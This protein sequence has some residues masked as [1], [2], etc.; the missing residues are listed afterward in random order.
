MFETKTLDSSIGALQP[1]DIAV[2]PTKITGGN[3]KLT[4][5]A[6]APANASS[7]TANFYVILDRMK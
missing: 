4:L 7:Y 2:N 3:A 5:E 6:V 1:I